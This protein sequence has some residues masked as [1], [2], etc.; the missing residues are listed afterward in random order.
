MGACVWARVSTAP[1]HFWLGCMCAFVCT[2][3]LW[4]A[5][6]GSGLRCMGWVLPG[7]CSC[8]VVRCRLCALPGFAAPGGR[9]CLVPV[10]VPW[11]WPAACLS[12]VPGGPALVRR[13]SSGLVALGAL[14]G[15]PTPWCLS[16]PRGHME[17]GR[18]QGSLCLSVT[19]AE[20]AA[21]GSL[22]VLPVQGPAMKLS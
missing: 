2:L 20:A 6:S 9:C 5:P 8:A 11:L 7:T 10:L 3:C 1:R 22:R 14:V 12:G 4:P 16:S 13:A 15:F 21:M 19:A 17:A 18:E